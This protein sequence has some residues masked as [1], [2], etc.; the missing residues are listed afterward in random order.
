MRD[1]RR[2]LNWHWWSMADLFTSRTN[3]MC[4]LYSVHCTVYCTVYC[5]VVCRASGLY[6][7]PSSEKFSIPTPKNFFGKINFLMYCQSVSS[8][9]FN[10]WVMLSWRLF[11]RMHFCDCNYACWRFGSEQLSRIV[12]QHDFDSKFPISIHAVQY[13]VQ[14]LYLFY[15]LVVENRFSS[16]SP[17]YSTHTLTSPW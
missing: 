12:S 2:H 1:W 6:Q 8:F 4:T 11:F 5:T 10:F 17:W 3:P 9:N 14:L 7:G 16:S 13:S 15:C